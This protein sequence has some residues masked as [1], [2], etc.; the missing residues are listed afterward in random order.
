MKNAL[1]QRLAAKFGRGPWSSTTRSSVV[2]LTL[3]SSAL[4]RAEE[5]WLGMYMQGVKIGYAGSVAKADKLDGKPATKYWSINV[6]KTEMIGSSME[7]N[8]QTSAWT[9]STGKIVRMDSASSS[10]GRRQTVSAL[11][12]GRKVEVRADNN[13]AIS[14]KVLEIPEGLELVL[15]PS[16][17]SAS[18]M[19]KG[20]GQSAKVVIFD[21]VTVDLVVNEIVSKGPSKVRIGKDE[22]AATLVEVR[23]PRASN[24]IF[25]SGKGD[26]IKIEGPLGIEMFPEARA[27]AMDFSKNRG[28][29]D[30]AEATRITVTPAIVNPDQTDSIT[31]IAKGMDLSAL[32]SDPHQTIT[33]GKDGWMVQL[34][35]V[36]QA[37]G[38]T[39][40]EAAKLQPDFLKGSMLIP[41]DDSELTARAKELAKSETDVLKIAENIRRGVY[42]QMRPNTGIGVLRDAREVLRTSEGLCRDHAILCAAL[43]RSAGVPARLVS[44]LVYQDGAFYFHAWVE[45]WSGS[46]WIGFDSTRPETPISAGHLKIA[47]G[48]VEEA[49]LFR[50]ISG[51]KM[52]VTDVKWQ[53]AGGRG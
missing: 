38:S 11:V 14:T 39:R 13:G 41:I 50:V 21:P 22:F 18:S 4:A 27:Q 42:D 15:D 45:A 49:F 31:L 53:A 17:S 20:L 44:G 28:T 7:M 46:Q 16:E 36:R 47:Q 8:L 2:V 12:K 52:V 1:A 9:D 37:T 32:P 30:L 26:L 25:Y 48:N 34:H 23:D 24:R 40:A 19:V 35:P 6:L 33:Q 5:S 29:I 3:L 10:Q 43:M 51:A